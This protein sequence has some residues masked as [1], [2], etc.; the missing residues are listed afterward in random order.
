MSRLSSLGPYRKQRQ[1]GVLCDTEPIHMYF[2]EQL[3]LNILLD[4][5]VVN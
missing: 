4:E 3:G 1:Q 2:S 5:K